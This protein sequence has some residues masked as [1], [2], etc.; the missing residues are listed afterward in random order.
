MV[1]DS[2]RGLAGCVAWGERQLLSLLVLIAPGRILVE[3]GGAPEGLA[4][5]GRAEKGKGGY[6]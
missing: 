4:Y 6:N 5:R 1:S 2:L 3:Y